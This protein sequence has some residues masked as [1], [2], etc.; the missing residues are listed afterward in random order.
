LANVDWI[1]IRLDYESNNTSYRKLA[2][3][4]SVS[5]N[6]LQCVAKRENWVK[7][8]QET[9]DK[10]IT[11]T[12]QKTVLKIAE[13]ISDRNAR[14]LS[15]S[16][17]ATDAIE[18]Y[19]K[20]KHY[21]QHVYKEKEYYEGKVESEKIVSKE[22]EVADTKSLSDM[23]RSLEML[24]KGQRLAE[25]LMTEHERQRLE[26]EKAKVD[27]SDPADLPD[28]GFIDAMKGSVKDI[29]ADEGNLDD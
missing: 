17:L 29:W 24:Q 11:K 23:V 5:F 27:P 19:F 13:K 10:I 25:G 7:A 22:L 21:K 9:Q 2:E 26:L 18:E 20:E 15:I 3:K 14:I 28:D 4:Y 8:K 12:R 6:T 16:D 1:K